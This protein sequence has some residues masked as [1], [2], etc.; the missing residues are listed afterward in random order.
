MIFTFFNCSKH[1]INQL[2][3]VGEQ[4]PD[5]AKYF[6]RN[7]YSPLYNDSLCLYKYIFNGILFY[8]EVDKNKKIFNILTGDS[9]FVTPEG[10]RVGNN[11]VKAKQIGK[12]V[13]NRKD[14]CEY[15]LPSKWR[16]LLKR[17][18]TLKI[19]N[20]FILG[21]SPEKMEIISIRNYKKKLQE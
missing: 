9:N 7:Y 12:L 6:N 14:L 16:V 2:P 13:Y 3:S 5:S 19:S 4:L 8:I 15:E 17:I 10:V 1:N 20:T 21:N 11:G 18:D